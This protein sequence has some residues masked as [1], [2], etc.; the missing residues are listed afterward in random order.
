[1]DILLRKNCAAFSESDAFLMNAPRIALSGWGM[2]AMARYALYW[3]DS[4]SRRNSWEADRATCRGI[5][6]IMVD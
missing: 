6:M 2:S 3:G 5:A 1:M 4:L